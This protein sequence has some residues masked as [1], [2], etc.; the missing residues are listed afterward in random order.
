MQTGSSAPGVELRCPQLRVPPEV[1]A[2]R[3]AKPPVEVKV[4]VR[5]KGVRKDFSIEREGKRSRPSRKRTIRQIKRVACR[6][7]TIRGCP[8]LGDEGQATAREDPAAAAR[9]S[10]RC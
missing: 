6:N 10:R 9:S 4:F 5:I 3:P 7:R 2:T 1:I 8:A